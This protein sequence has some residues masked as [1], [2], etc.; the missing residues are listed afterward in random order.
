M[1]TGT[2]FAPIV[3]GLATFTDPGGPAIDV[4]G[5]YT[6]TANQT[7]SDSPA[8]NATSNQFSI[9]NSLTW[10]GSGNGTSWS[11]AKN[12]SE[13]VAPVSGDSLVFAAGG[14]LLTNNDITGLSV[15]NIDIQ[16]AGYTLGGD[17]ISLTGG[18]TSE[19][20]NNTYDIATTLVGSPTIDDQT[21]DLTI[22]SVL[23]GASLTVSGAGIAT[24]DDTDTYTG[25]TTLTAGVTIDDSAIDDAFGDG[26]LTIGAG[27]SAVSID[28]TGSGSA[29]LD[30]NLTFQDGATLA[31]DPTVLFT[32]SI[33]VNGEAVGDPVGHGDTMALQ[34]DIGGTGTLTLMG[35]GVV[36]IS[37]KVADTVQIQVPTTTLDLSGTLDSLN[38]QVTV[39]GGTLMLETGLTGTGGIDVQS[40]MLNS[41][42]VP[43][44]SG[45][46]TLERTPTGQAEVQLS[47]VTDPLGTGTIVIATPTGTNPLTP[48]ISEVGA[49]GSLLL[50]NTLDFETS[51]NLEVAGNVTIEK[52]VTVN[53][54]Q[55]Y[56]NNS[57]APAILTFSNGI[58][59]V[60]QLTDN[61]DGTLT[62]SGDVNASVTLTAQ[63]A[64][65]TLA[66]GGNLLGAASGNQVFDT[67]GVIQ[68]LS[69]VTGN[70]GI[71]IQYGTLAAGA[72]P[73]FTGNITVQTPNDTGESTSLV[74]T[75]DAND[76]GSAPLIFAAAPK[77]PNSFPAIVGSE[78]NTPLNFNDPIFL[79]GTTVTVTGDTVFNG[80]IT[81]TGNNTISAGLV[82]NLSF[83]GTMSGTGTL[84]MSMNN[85]TASITGTI[86][87]TL[88]VQAASGTVN[89]GATLLGDVGG[90]NQV[91]LTGGNVQL[92]DALTGNG[93]IDI[94]SGTLIAAGAPNYGGNITAETPQSGLTAEVLATTAT[95]VLGKGQL[96][97]A[98]PTN[99]SGTTG[100]YLVDGS[101]TASLAIDTPVVFEGATVNITGNV[102]FAGSV[103]VN[104]NS[105]L[106]APTGTN[107]AFTGTIAGNSILDSSLTSSTVS[108]SGTIANGAVF[109]LD[110]NAPVLNLS[111]T[112]NGATSTTDGQIIID[113]GT[114]NLL[115]GFQGSG[116]IELKGG[117]LASSAPVGQFTGNIIIDQGQS[118]Q[119]VINAT[120]GTSVL[121]TGQLV[122]NNLT[123]PSSIVPLLINTKGNS[124]TLALDDTLT[125]GS[126]TYLQTQGSV[127]FNAPV[128]TGTTTDNLF[129]SSISDVTNLAGGVGGTGTL[130][131]YGIGSAIL[132]GTSTAAI[133]LPDQ[134][135]SLG[136]SLSSMI[137]GNAVLNGGA[138]QITVSTGTVILEGTGSNLGA[139]T[140]AGGI[141]MLAGTLT[142]D[143]AGIYRGDS[144]YTGSITIAAGAVASDN[145]IADLHPFGSGTLTLNGGTLRNAVASNPNGNNLTGV[146]NS[147][148]ATNSPTIAAGTTRFKLEGS[149]TITNGTLLLSGD[150]ALFGNLSGAGNIVLQSG[151]DTL[152]VASSNPSYTGQVSS[153][154]GTILA[155]AS[156]NYPFGDPIAPSKLLAPITYFIGT[157][158]IGRQQSSTS[159]F[160]AVNS[161]TDPII[162]NPIDL[163]SGTL[164]LEGLLT[165]P[166]GITVDAGATLEIE[167]AGSQIVTSGA[168]TGAGTI[169]V[170]PGTTFSTPGG[171][172]GFTGT[173]SQ[174]TPTLVTPT[175]TVSDAGGV[176]NGSSYPATATLSASGVTP[177]NSLEGVSPTFTYYT[178]TSTIGVGTSAAPD[179]AG[180]YT[181]V[182][183]FAGS[184]DYAPVV[185]TPVT[186][187][188]TPAPATSKLAFFV[189]PRTTEAGWLGPVVIF[190]ENSKGKLATSDDSTV[191]LSVASGPGNLHGQ[192]SVRAFH[193][194][195]IFWNLYLTTAGTYT[196]KATD[197]TDTS[198]LTHSFK[199]TPAA[200]ARLVF[201]D[202]PNSTGAGDQ[203]GPIVVNVED[204]YGNIETGFNSTVTLFLETN[205]RQ[206]EGFLSGTTRVRAMNGV[207]T[208][209]NLSVNAGGTYRLE[210]FL[211]FCAAGSSNPFTISPAPPSKHPHP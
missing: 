44:Y 166:A 37:G 85:N 150:I 1:L 66:I 82:T 77:T 123:G 5:E 40:G 21:G 64:N 81:V 30:N 89:L 136:G 4:D 154:G 176:A 131:L 192:V 80:P 138:N 54:T 111:G 11:D 31:T 101:S 62:V 203:I 34:G 122:I 151:A 187:I 130:N 114:A 86:A 185:S 171:T 163:E 29:E 152:E 168:L 167:G 190:I 156:Q 157:I 197:G 13:D 71:D 16:G 52:M 117:T 200:P 41:A 109:D 211:D 140:G 148:V 78:D 46:I 72:L 103:T 162:G 63:D 184:T 189:E 87:P 7:G 116:A 149:L 126:D 196:L 70:A 127:T 15:A 56:I 132:S 17:A 147:I 60:G 143:A 158:S 20:G 55:S 3:N 146:S 76:F 93:G 105:T 27:S 208:F 191:T 107:L 91:V 2:T 115:T 104:A 172:T 45:T 169:I 24:F 58:Q 49:V 26:A 186:F 110:G 112:L 36:T 96:I 94:Q 120:P 205:G 164:I 118:V 69:S 59:G 22:E 159:T 202:E 173:I 177:T 51:G 137:V 23:S 83:T 155:L 165:F 113:T 199:I 57:S 142:T 97:F 48:T 88:V 47:V 95:S 28:D 19:S 33:T 198:A 160:T 134:P 204:Q 178:G 67:G 79:N 180:T 195:A 193:G 100:P 8:A 18:L 14:T 181:V 90:P 129:N 188:I 182:G 139:I 25:P 194:V 84:A 108:I 210:A 207:A 9:A 135:Q 145:D 38:N 128:V 39:N 73:G 161:I 106:S 6:F 175:L 153:S 119:D 170:D 10:T 99:T 179:T 144:D 53:S 32:G 125:Y 124:Q 121:G 98:A 183:A 75:P 35:V 65:G 92:L 12:W 42:G 50:N 201:L 74:V 133:V 141:N 68:L 209:S 61:M 43:D 174:G 102:N 206:G